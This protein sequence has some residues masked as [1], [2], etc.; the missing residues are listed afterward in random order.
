ML[1]HKNEEPFKVFL[2]SIDNELGR[3]KESIHLFEWVIEDRYDNKMNS[4]LDYYT[5]RP[6]LLHIDTEDILFE[7]QEM[8]SY[9]SSKE[10]YEKCASLQKLQEMYKKN[11]IELK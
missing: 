5:D 7:L 9:F 1:I 2:A 3:D 6:D 10:E 11:L 4:N 8:L